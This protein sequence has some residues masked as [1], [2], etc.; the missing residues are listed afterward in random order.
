MKTLVC[1]WLN[2]GLRP[3]WEFAS[4]A[5]LYGSVVR[6]K[7]QP[8]DCDL[9]LVCNS[10]FHSCS[11]DNL[12][13]YKIAL[14]EKFSKDFSIQLSIKLLTQGEAKDL[15]KL[16]G[17]KLF[18]RRDY[19]GE[20]YSDAVILISTASSQTHHACISPVSPS[21]PRTPHLLPHKDRHA[22]LPVHVGDEIDAAPSGLCKLRQMPTG[23]PT[24]CAPSSPRPSSRAS[25]CRGPC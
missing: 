25:C 20:Y 24:R 7:V 10:F 18:F 6:G 21:S 13:E 9:I 14:S 5:C 4:L 17:P 1:S 3:V 23:S 19:V 16:S 11:W 12:V 8:N 15:T 22:V 2:N